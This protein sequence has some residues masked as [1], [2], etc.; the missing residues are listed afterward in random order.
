MTSTGQGGSNNSINIRP[1]IYTDVDITIT[2]NFGP[3]YL[4]DLTDV[5]RLELVFET[6]G[7]EI[8]ELP[9]IYINTDWTLDNNSSRSG[10]VLLDQEFYDYSIQSSWM[11]PL[12]FIS[13]YQ[14]NGKKIKIITIG[15][16]YH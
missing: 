11:S 4:A 1:S 9:S 13:L 6:L 5:V 12:G 7:K 14:Q 2:D 15:R 3:I 16:H 8:K 10:K